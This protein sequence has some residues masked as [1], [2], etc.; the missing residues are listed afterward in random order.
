MHALFAHR[1]P[2]PHRTHRDT[3]LEPHARRSTRRRTPH[4]PRRPYQDALPREVRRAAP[5]RPRRRAGRRGVLRAGVPRRRRRARPRDVRLRLAHLGLLAKPSRRQVDSHRAPPSPGRHAPHGRVRHAL[6]LSPQRPGP[7]VRQAGTRGARR[8]ISRW[9]PR[10]SPARDRCRHDG[11]LAHLRHQALPALFRFQARSRPRLGR[12]RRVARARG[13]LRSR[14]ARPTAGPP[15]QR[16]L[17]SARPG[18]PPRPRPR[19]LPRPRL[20]GHA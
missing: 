11:R 4:P 20:L 8:G 9:Q 14:A 19:D 17:P 2:R 12:S 1:P 13:G 5:A 16:R 15:A 6:K 18:P 10:A 7:L 3:H